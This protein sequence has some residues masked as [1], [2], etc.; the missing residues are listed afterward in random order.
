M[1][2]IGITHG[3]N[4]HYYASWIEAAEG[5]TVVPITE[6]NLSE[7]ADCS[8]IILSGG[9]DVH[10]ALYGK[11]EYVRE[12]QLSDFDESRD[13]FEIR[14]LE[15]VFKNE[16]PL[17]GICRGMQ[18]ANVW[19]GGT[20]VSDLES[21]GKRNHRR[22][23]STTDNTHLIRIKAGSQLETITGLTGGT[24]NSAHHQAIDRVAEGWAIT[25]W[26]ED[27]VAEAMGRSQPSEHY[28]LFVQW[29]PERM[30]DQQ[31]PLTYRLREDFL[32]ACKTT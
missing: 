7:V 19:L 20:L 21:S 28:T 3:R 22:L 31:N 27:E 29:H 6:N 15:T 25:A 13:A 5:T 11:P 4:Y 24:V 12:F 9:Q 1:L 2:R 30:T 14:T 26:S 32:R 10:P 17:L 8:G 16:I 23:D 18:L